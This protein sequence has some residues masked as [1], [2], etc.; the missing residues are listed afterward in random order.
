MT[1]REMVDIMLAYD[2]G[3]QIQCKFLHEND[4]CWRDAE[5]NWDWNRYAYR[6]KPEEEKPVHITSRVLTPQEFA[7]KMESLTMNIDTEGMHWD[8]DD[9]MCETLKALGY[10]EGVEIFENTLKWYA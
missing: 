5:P 7:E 1:I 10:E 9:L 4:D 3:K 8:M 2:E 6:I